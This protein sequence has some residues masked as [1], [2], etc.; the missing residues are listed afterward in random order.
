MMLC[1]VSWQSIHAKSFQLAIQLVQCRYAA[2]QMIQIAQEALH[3]CVHRI[4]KQLPVEPNVV[5]PF[6]LLGEF[7]A[8]EQELLAGMRRT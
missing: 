2:V 5:V 1:S 7:A 8:H 4:V 6:A 3:A